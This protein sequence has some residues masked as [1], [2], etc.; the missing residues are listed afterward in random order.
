MTKSKNVRAA[1]KKSAPR[2]VWLAGG[3]AVL[4]LV[5]VLVWFASANSVPR[6]NPIM[7]TNATA[8]ANAA[9]ITANLPNTTNAFGVGTLIGKSAPAF[10]LPDAQGKPYQFQPGDGKKYV[11]A[12]NMGFA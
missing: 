4:I 10:T 12:F 2:W 7:N 9:D 1:N 11:L 8:S 5:A 3:A 6:A